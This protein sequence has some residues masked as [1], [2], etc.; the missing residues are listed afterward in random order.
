MHIQPWTF[1]RYCTYFQHH[2]ERPQERRPEGLCDTVSHQDAP[3]LGLMKPTHCT[4]SKQRR[5]SHTHSQMSS[6]PPCCESDMMV[7]IPPCT[8]TV[9]M[10][11]DRKPAS[12]TPSCVESGPRHRTNQK[13][14]CGANCFHFTVSAAG[15]RA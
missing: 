7:E 11:T 3:S 14:S 2:G 5:T 15:L 9:L 8:A 13:K 1:H 6:L 12:M 10:M 4:I